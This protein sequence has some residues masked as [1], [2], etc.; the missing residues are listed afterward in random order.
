MAQMKFIASAQGAVALRYSPDDT[1]PPAGILM[2][3]LVNFVGSEYNFSMK[4]DVPPGL[5]VNPT[6]MFQSGATAINDQKTPIHQLTLTV[7]ATVV[8]AQTTDLAEMVAAQFVDKIDAT[9]GY[10]IANH[11]RDRYYQSVIIAEFEPSLERQIAA[12]ARAQEVLQNEIKREDGSFAFKRLAFGRGENSLILPLGR[13]SVD[14][15]PK[16]DFLIERR[17]GEPL[18]LNRYFCSAP[19]KTDDL[20][21]ILGMVERAM[22]G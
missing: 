16:S 2:R 14:D 18:S 15:I 20:V 17:A 12:L 7:G 11:I 8:A 3:D 9:F 5:M 22:Q 6:F 19:V 4:P 1:S 10:K 21:R 13:F